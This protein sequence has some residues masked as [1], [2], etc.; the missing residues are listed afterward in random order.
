MFDRAESELG[1]KTV[2]AISADEAF[3]YNFHKG[4]IDEALIKREIPDFRERTFYVSGP[5]AMVVRF[6]DAL[7]GLGVARSRIKVDF[8]PGFA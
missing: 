6:H 2:Y 1:L 7:R 4:F 8:F 5:R 3:G